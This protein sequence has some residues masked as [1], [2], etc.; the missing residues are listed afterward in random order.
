MEKW[1][2]IEKNANYASEEKHQINK[3]NAQLCT[4]GWSGQRKTF[5]SKST[6]LLQKD[7]Y[8]YLQ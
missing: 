6:Q 5:P 2:S 1:G 4:H 3:K 7:I 8:T